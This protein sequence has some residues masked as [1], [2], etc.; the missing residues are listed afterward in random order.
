M[1]NPRDIAG[2]RTKKKKKKKKKKNA[3]TLTI[4]IIKT[5][6]IIVIMDEE[7]RQP[8][9]QPLAL[10]ASVAEYP[11]RARAARTRSQRAVVTGR[12][13]N[14]SCSTAVTSQLALVALSKFTAPLTC[15]TTQRIGMEAAGTERRETVLITELKRNGPDY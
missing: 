10:T 5:I 14:A 6:T 2:E 9:N 13:A 11:R 1:V 4:T 7:L 12:M 3:I 8:A 15:S